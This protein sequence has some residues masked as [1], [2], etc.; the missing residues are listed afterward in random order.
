MKKLI[1]IL[2]S[3]VALPVTAGIVLKSGNAQVLG[4][5]GN[6]VV[7]FDYS[8]AR[9]LGKDLSLEDFIEQKGYKYENNWEMAQTM[10]HKDFVKRFN[11]K[12]NSLMLSMDS[13]SKTSY[14]MIIQVRSIDMGSTA[15][16]LLPVGRKTDGGV[17][18]QGRIYIKDLKGN[19][20]CQLRF[21]DIKGMGS[22]SIQ[23][24]MM[25]AYQSLYQSLS[26]FI[27]KNVGQKPE[28]LDDDDD[29]ESEEEDDDYDE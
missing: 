10:S 18:L 11:K 20:V 23:S 22:S 1:L 8:N 6:V 24:R 3:A 9:I 29:D 12:S 21:S 5:K 27:K 17:V 15:K 26:K 13:T 7:Q 28:S 16:S 4:Q 14:K 25:F 2:L 19:E